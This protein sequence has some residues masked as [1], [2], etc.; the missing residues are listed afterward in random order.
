M[1]KVSVMALFGALL[2][3]SCSAFKEKACDLFEDKLGA[4]ASDVVANKLQ[5]ENK[6]AVQFDI[7]KLIAD[8]G[9]CKTVQPTGPIADAVCPIAVNSVVDK[10]ASVAVPAHWKCS[11]SDV[12]GLV[13]PALTDLCKKIPVSEGG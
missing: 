12:K 3:S 11:L 2:L 13:K 7:E 10:L 4:V 1:R 9:V 8:I 6:A 5:C